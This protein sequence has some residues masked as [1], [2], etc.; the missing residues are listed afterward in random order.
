MSSFASESLL[1]AGKSVAVIGAIFIVQR[2]LM[3]IGASLFGDLGPL[4]G[5]SIAMYLILLAY[6]RG[7]ISIPSAGLLSA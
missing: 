6:Q 4:I 2:F 5:R 7:Y 1:V 3:E